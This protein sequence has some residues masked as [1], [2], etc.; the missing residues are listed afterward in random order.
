MT[1]KERLND[2]MKQAMKTQD[3]ERLATIRLARAAILFVEKNEQRE[4]TDDDVIGL[5]AKEIKQ[6]KDAIEAVESAADRGEYVDKIRQE[7]EILS[8]YLPRQMTALE[9]RQLVQDVIARVGAQGPKD[10]GKVMAAL[11]PEVKGKADGKLVS[12]IVKE[13]LG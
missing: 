13:S 11:M 2:D 8:G 7:I 10:T 5:L 9:I 6:R 4:L 1:L 3:K 12:Q